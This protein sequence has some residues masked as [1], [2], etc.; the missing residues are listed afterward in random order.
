MPNWCH[1]RLEIRGTAADIGS[2]REAVSWDDNP[3]DFERVLPTPD[4]FSGHDPGLLGQTLAAMGGA[5][6]E[7]WD[8]FSWRK[9]HWGCGAAPDP[10]EMIEW[11]E[12]GGAVPLV[13]IDFDTPWTPPLGVLRELSRQHPSLVVTLAYEEPGVGFGGLVSWTAGEVFEEAELLTDERTVRSRG[14][15]RGAR[16]RAS[17]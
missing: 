6:T 16:S 7:P 10:D 15:S 4:T 13:R 9:K 14:G 12:V 11:I 3:F 8:R 1:N 2:L 5:D 17:A